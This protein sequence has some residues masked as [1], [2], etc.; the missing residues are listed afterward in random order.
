MPPLKPL[1]RALQKLR[2][3]Q[4]GWERG[5]AKRF[6]VIVLLP[7]PHITSMRPKLLICQ[8]YTRIYLKVSAKMKILLLK[9][10]LLPVPFFLNKS[11]A[12][13]YISAR[14]FFTKDIR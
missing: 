4:L 2:Y 7:T 6:F 3:T 14:R 5:L 1:L 13:F 12:S 9:S 8:G 11:Y 10:L